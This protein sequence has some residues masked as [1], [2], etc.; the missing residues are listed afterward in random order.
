[1]ILVG[2]AT[3]MVG[4]PSGKTKERQLLDLDVMQHNLNSQK[5]QLQKFLDFEGENAARVV[6]NF[7][8]FK[9]IDFN[10]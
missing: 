4:D 3:G 2:G 8:W 9:I 1:M 5:N 6:N 10:W 7:D